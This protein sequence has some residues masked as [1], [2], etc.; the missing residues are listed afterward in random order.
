[1]TTLANP[2]ETLS[3][4]VRDLRRKLIDHGWEHTR[5]SGG[6]SGRADN[7]TE[8]QIR[9]GYVH[10]SYRL[11]VFGRINGE[12]HGQHYLD[13]SRG[14]SPARVVEIT[15]ALADWDGVVWPPHPDFQPSST[16][17]GK[18]WPQ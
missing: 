3:A 7:G 11:L 2:D 16:G 4:Q 17:Q 5:R 9:T 14:V 15:Q 1:M 18:G 13:F 12:R 10:G 8:I 6:L